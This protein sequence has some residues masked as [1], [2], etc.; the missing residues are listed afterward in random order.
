MACPSTGNVVLRPSGRFQASVPV[1]RGSARRHYE[2]FDTKAQADAWCA[3]AVANLAA[4]LPLPS[5]G[6]VLCNGDPS[7]RAR[8]PSARPPV[9]DARV[10]LTVEQVTDSWFHE[11]YVDGRSGG[12]GR[13]NS[14][15]AMLNRRVVPFLTPIFDTGSPLTR[16]AYRTY[17]GD[18]GRPSEVQQRG[19]RGPK[20]REGLSQE[21]LSGRRCV[22]R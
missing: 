10:R 20:T 7:R 22:T 16:E 11:V 6:A 12:A 19:Q 14:V 13:A 2:M 17:L 8:T 18:L 15:R 9:P 1:E 3:L 4:G 5:R 21:T